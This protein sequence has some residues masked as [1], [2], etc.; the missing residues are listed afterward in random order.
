V[1]YFFAQ[2][3]CVVILDVVSREYSGT[4][5][6][7]FLL[8]GFL[9]STGRRAPRMRM[10]TPQWVPISYLGDNSFSFLLFPNVGRVSKAECGGALS[11]GNASSPPRHIGE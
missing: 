7:P 5:P 6:F 10:A 11:I 2:G 1:W 8:F 9:Y 3:R 4:V